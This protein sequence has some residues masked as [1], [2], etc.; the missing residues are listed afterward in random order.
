MTAI[1]FDFKKAEESRR[2]F[3]KCLDMLKTSKKDIYIFG[4]GV[5]ANSLT[6]YLN[7]NEITIKGYVV[8]DEYAVSNPANKFLALNSVISAD[9]MFL[10]YGIGGGFSDFYTSK[11]EMLNLA[12]S[13]C[14]NSSFI[15]LN[16]YW[17]VDIGLINHEIIDEAFMKEHFDEFSETYDMLEDEFSRDTM[18]A[19]L[20]ASIGHDATQL[21]KIWDDKD[22]DYNLDLLFGKCCDGLVVE[23]GAFDGKSIVQMSEYTG[24]KYEM[25]ALECD[26]V[27][28]DKCCHTVS[29]YDNIKVI[30]KGV[31]DKQ[32]YLKVVRSRDASYLVELNEGVDTSGSVEVTDIDT[33]VG[34]KKVSVLTMDIEGSEMKALT[35][36]ER[37]I[38]AGANLAV[39]IYHKNIDLIT[40]P[41]YIKSLNPNYKFYLRYNRGASQCRTGDETTLYA[42]I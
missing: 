17:F 19:Y 31:W 42:L 28:Y 11:I 21:S 14:S 6:E 32:A 3:E 13:K 34:S 1:P 8:D 18:L 7:V 15:V 40:I 27:N 23:C 33:L 16:D 29:G 2:D 4:A 24:N 37:V 9:N 36:A 26:D 25:L 12:V 35:G 38:A 22:H 10:L 30:K 20:Y 5:Y 41:Q 39:R